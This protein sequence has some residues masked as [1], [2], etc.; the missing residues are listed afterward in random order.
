MSFHAKVS[1]FRKQFGD[2]AFNATLARCGYKRIEEVA[3]A[4]QW[5][6]EAAMFSIHAAAKPATAPKVSGS[7]TTTINTEE[8]YSKRRAAVAAKHQAADDGFAD[9]GSE[10]LDDAGNIDTAKVYAKRHAAKRRA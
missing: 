10:L 9:D 1:K 6:L 5:L 3:E 4:D 2:A 8:I 7:G